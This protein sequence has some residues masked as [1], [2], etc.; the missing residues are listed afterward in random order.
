MEESKKPSAEEVKILDALYEKI[1]N[2]Q[3]FT[4][5]SGGF[6]AYEGLGCIYWHMVSKLLLAVQENITDSRDDLFS[7]YKDVKK[8]LGASKTPTE[9][10]AFPFDP[11][12]HTP[13]LQGAKQPGMTGQVKEEVLTRWGEL[14]LKIKE[15]KASFEPVFLDKAEFDG[16]KLDF[17]WCGTKIV[18]DNEKAESITVEFKD[19]NKA[20]FE[21]NTLPGSESKKL[22]ARTGEIA[23]I[24]VG[25]KK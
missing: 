19:G 14:G 4:G 1:F 8:G 9:Y 22:F 25:L 7:F 6:Y 21:G 15:G 17:T 13:Y 24:T 5:R 20:S 3:S 2:H 11:Y 23:Q 18:Y 12:S 16:G 10:G